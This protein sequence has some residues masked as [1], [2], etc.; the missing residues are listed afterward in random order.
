LPIE[1]I[2]AGQIGAPAVR[3]SPTPETDEKVDLI[4]EFRRRNT[5]TLQIPLKHQSE[6]ELRYSIAPPAALTLPPQ[7]TPKVDISLPNALLTPELLALAQKLANVLLAP[8]ALQRLEPLLPLIAAQNGAVILREALLR[9]ARNRYQLISELG[10]SSADM[11]QIATT[12]IPPALAQSIALARINPKLRGREKQIR[13]QALLELGTVLFVAQGRDI[14]A[15]QA[16]VK[17]LTAISKQTVSKNIPLPEIYTSKKADRA[18]IQRPDMEQ[19]ISAQMASS[20]E[21]PK[22]TKELQSSIAEPLPYRREVHFELMQERERQGAVV[23]IAAEYLSSDQAITV[24]AAKKATKLQVPD[25]TKGPVAAAAKGAR[26]RNIDSQPDAEQLPALLP[27]KEKQSDHIHQI[28]S[29]IHAQTKPDSVPLESV[30]TE[31]TKRKAI[32][33]NN[34]HLSESVAPCHKTVEELNITSPTSRDTA[35]DTKDLPPEQSCEIRFEES[36]AKRR[37]SVRRKIKGRQQRERKERRLKEILKD[38]LL[39]IAHYELRAKKLQLS[40]ESKTEA[41]LAETEELLESQLIEQPNNHELETEAHSKSKPIR[42]SRAGRY[43]ASRQRR[44]KS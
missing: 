9:I 27:N 22:S 17:N 2:I 37:A 34:T 33:T 4:E 38:R 29:M 24:K 10:I 7:N 28:S 18:E 41:P 13:Q 8:E 43:R 26:L 14:R 1:R 31:A 36:A 23:S 12:N 3:G 16:V 30:Q 19:R 39:A 6:T 25:R 32:G 21:T 11:N 20:L 44:D 35:T 5:P 15:V 40:I 42:S